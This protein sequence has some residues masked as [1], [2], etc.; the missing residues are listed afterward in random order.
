VAAAAAPVEPKVRLTLTLAALNR[1]RSVFFVVTGA[2]KAPAMRR[3]ARES[4]DYHL[5]PAAGIHP[6]GGP[7]VW[8]LDGA[9]AA[10]L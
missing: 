10:S 3:I 9:A 4:P 2:D 1:S 7:A 5:C 8:W 6:A